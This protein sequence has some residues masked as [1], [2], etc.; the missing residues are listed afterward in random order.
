MPPGKP[1]ATPP[2]GNRFESLQEDSPPSPVDHD[3][4]PSELKVTPTNKDDESPT[5]ARLN[6]QDERLDRI[7]EMLQV[8]AKAVQVPS[9]SHSEKVVKVVPDPVLPPNDTTE[10]EDD[11]PEEEEV[12]E[13][14][15]SVLTSKDTSMS[16]TSSKV[17]VPKSVSKKIFPTPFTGHVARGPPSE[18]SV[19]FTPATRTPRQS[20]RTASLYSKKD[21]VKTSSIP[22][23]VEKHAQDPKKS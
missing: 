2:K 4:V 7:E 17:N 12:H 3:P 10:D 5:T 1:P 11:F 19:G 21:V 13:D 6:S 23:I 15:G 20:L 14:D 8:I 16:D 18:D 22:A 9:P